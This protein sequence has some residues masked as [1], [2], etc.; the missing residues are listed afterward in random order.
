METSGELATGSLKDAKK[1]LRISKYELLKYVKCLQNAMHHGMG[2]SLDDFLPAV[3]PP[4]DVELS[5]LQKNPT[6]IFL[7]D[8]ES[9][10]S[11]G[12]SFHSFHPIYLSIKVSVDLG[13]GGLI[14]V[15]DLALFILP[16]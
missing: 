11:L 15:N 16:P 9:Q 4:A 13:E 10:Q 3:R 2:R 6:F 7:T 12:Y 14:L 1:Q 8:M 5:A